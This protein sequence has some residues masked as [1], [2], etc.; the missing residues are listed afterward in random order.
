MCTNTKTVTT[1]AEFDQRLDE[2][3]ASAR[4]HGIDVEG[5]W[6]CRGAEDGFDYEVLVSAVTPQV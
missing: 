2:L 6:A 4:R 5:P 3:V 1:E